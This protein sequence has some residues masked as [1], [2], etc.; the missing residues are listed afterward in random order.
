MYIYMCVCM[1]VCS[2]KT[3][4]RFPSKHRLYRH[5]LMTRHSQQT[6]NKQDGGGEGGGFP[7]IGSAVDVDWA[8]E[9]YS[10]LTVVPRMGI[11]T[12]HYHNFSLAF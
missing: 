3:K 2:G 11:K 5:C 8:G 4:L 10:T 1:C 6:L 12:N 7:E 9:G